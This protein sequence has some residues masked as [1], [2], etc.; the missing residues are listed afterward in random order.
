MSDLIKI[1]KILKEANP[2]IDWDEFY[3]VNAEIQKVCGK[4]LV[5]LKILKLITDIKAN[6]EAYNSAPLLPASK[7]GIVDMTNGA[8]FCYIHS[9]EPDRN[10]LSYIERVKEYWTEHDERF[11]IYKNLSGLSEFNFK[12]TNWFKF[13]DCV[14]D[15]SNEPKYETEEEKKARDDDIKHQQEYKEFLEEKERKRKEEKALEEA[16]K[17]ESE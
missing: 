8:V 12:L 3:S 1:A 16:E 10:L 6:P 13:A 17:E 2:D 11:N 5:D 9:D 15:F 14:P 7:N 4:P